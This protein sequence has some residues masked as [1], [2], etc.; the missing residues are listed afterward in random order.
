M[1][2]WYCFKDKAKMQDGRVK[3]SQGLVEMDQDA[4]VCPVCRTAY[5]TEDV[6]E[7]RLLPAEEL[8]EEK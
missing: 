4:I 5:I 8:M 1:A 3:L 2:D 7:N 6:T